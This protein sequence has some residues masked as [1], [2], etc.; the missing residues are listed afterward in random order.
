[1][2]E[3]ELGPTHPSGAAQLRPFL[4]VLWKEK[5]VCM[6][7]CGSRVKGRE[8][9]AAGCPGHSKTGE[10]TGPQVKGLRGVTQRWQ[11]V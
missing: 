11:R 5:G 8:A 2:G 9:P 7:K 4:T 1:M 10:Q 6:L 3:G